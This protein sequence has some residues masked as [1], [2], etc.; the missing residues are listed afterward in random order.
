MFSSKISICTRIY[1]PTYIHIW[2]CLFRFAYLL[3]KLFCFYGNIC[4][5]LIITQTCEKLY[6]PND[7][8]ILAFL[9]RQ[10]C[11]RFIFFLF[12]FLSTLD[13]FSNV[14]ALHTFLG[15]LIFRFLSSRLHTLWRLYPTKG[16]TNF[17]NSRSLSTDL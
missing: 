11:F 5:V 14:T 12:H 6:V 1:L 10:H 8:I 7:C 4:K 9:W 3:N 15:R 17:K 16:G 13:V 2:R